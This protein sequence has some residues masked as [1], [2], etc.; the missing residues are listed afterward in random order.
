MNVQQ[1]LE[2]ISEKLNMETMSQ[3]EID[4]MSLSLE[5][6]QDVQRGDYAVNVRQLEQ[7]K[8]S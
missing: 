3:N 7:L 5:T 1:Q 2:C 8:E 6:L 4:E